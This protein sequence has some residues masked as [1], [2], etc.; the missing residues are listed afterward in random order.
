MSKPSPLVYIIVL[1][2]NGKKWLESLFPSLLKTNYPN[3]HILLVDNDSSDDTERFIRKHPSVEYLKLPQNIGYAGGNNA[4][5]RYVLKKEP[6]YIC[7]LNNDT[8]VMPNWLTE[9]VTVTRSDSA[10]ALTGPMVMDWTGKN[11]SKGTSFMNPYLEKDYKNK[12]LKSVYEVDSIEG[13]C[14]LIRTS[15]LKKIGLFDE[16]YFAYFEEMDLQRRIKAA[17]YKIIQATCSKIQH[18]EKGSQMRDDNNLK[19]LYARNELY[20][21]LKNPNNPFGSNLLEFHKQIFMRMFW[22][23]IKFKKPGIQILLKAYLWNLFHLLTTRLIRRK[24]IQAI[25]IEKTNEVINFIL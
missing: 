21:I 14:M 15:V 3:F 13:C 10:I 1:T 11:I 5:I 7:L 2:W 8:K 4:G 19:Y 9:L 16:T 6:K 25:I 22:K 17:G 18:F 23:M 12:E 24:E 20:F